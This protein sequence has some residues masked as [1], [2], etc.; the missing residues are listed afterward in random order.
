MCELFKFAS[1]CS[2]NL[3]FPVL[4]DL[5]KEYRGIM[6][7]LF[8]AKCLGL[9]SAG[10]SSALDRYKNAERLRSW[11]NPTPPTI[12]GEKTDR[13]RVIS[14][15]KIHYVQMPDSAAANPGVSASAVSKVTAIDSGCSCETKAGE[16]GFTPLNPSMKALASLPR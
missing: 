16:N 6:K 12:V 3:E 8:I 9:A 7:H 11:S 2:E 15:G 4:N 13:D 1:F 5:E 10:M 14:F